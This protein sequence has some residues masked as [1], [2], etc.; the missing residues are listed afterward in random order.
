MSYSRWLTSSWYTFWSVSGL[1]DK[2]EQVIEIMYSIDESW[3]VS[4]KD[5]KKDFE[6]VINSMPHFFPNATGEEIEELRTYLNEFIKDV[7]E[8]L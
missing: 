7:E 8:R 3:R 4:Y 1:E 5:L 2:E 6:G